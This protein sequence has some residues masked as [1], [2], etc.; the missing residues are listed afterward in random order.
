MELTI[1]NGK[2]M[3]KDKIGT[4]AFSHVFLGQDIKYD[5]DVAIKLEEKKN[6]KQVL[7][8]EAKL[9]KYLL[10]VFPVPPFLHI[11]KGTKTIRPLDSKNPLRV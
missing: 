9:L 6:K 11:L 5:Q 2:Y 7:F 4:G 8:Y 1:G 10:Q 3:L